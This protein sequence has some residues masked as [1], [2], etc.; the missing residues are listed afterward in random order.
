MIAV[1]V[2]GAD[3]VEANLGRALSEM[4]TA[5]ERAIR[6]ASLLLRRELAAQMTG[7]KGHSD[8]F[9][10]TGAAGNMLG[11]R[12]GQSVLHLSP[13]GQVYRRGGSVLSA[14]GSPD[15]H[16]L[17]HEEG[18][19]VRG[20]PY[21]LIPLAPVLN[22]GS[23]TIK[24]EW[25]NP[26]SRSDLIVAKSKAGNLFLGQYRRKKNPKR[27]NKGLATA[28][29][30]RAGPPPVWPGLPLKFLLK[31]SVTYRGRHVFATV[32][33]RMGAPTVGA[34]QAEVNVVVQRGNGG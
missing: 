30:F 31:R 23:G 24:A 18:G 8:F 26:R 4:K 32:T 34:L 29:A 25:R 6:A 28:A 2:R 7:P 22:P 1:S 16:V 5:P 21:L 12:S 27:L 33:G 15:A 9:G 10:V 19:T 3:V 13:G 20:N 17:L 14:V 11:K